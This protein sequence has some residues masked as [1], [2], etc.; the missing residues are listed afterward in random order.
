[1]E[2]SARN[3]D[4]DSAREARGGREFSRHADEL[5]SPELALVDP[6]PRLRAHGRRYPIAHAAPGERPGPHPP[7]PLPRSPA[8]A[9][10][11]TTP[12][13]RYPLWARITAAL[14]IL[15]LGILIGGAAIPHAQDRPRVVPPE[16]DVAICERPD[17]RPLPR[18]IGPAARPDRQ[19]VSRRRGA[20]S[21]AARY[22]RPPG[23][24]A[25]LGEHLDR[26]QGV[27]GSSPPSSTKACSFEPRGPAT[28]PR[29]LQ[30]MTNKEW[31]WDKTLFGG[32]ARYYREGRLA[33]PPDLA[34]AFQ[35]ELEL[36]GTGRLLDV[37]CGTGK[38]RS[39]SHRCT[40]RALASTPM[41]R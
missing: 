5:I 35:E 1:M 26:T 39:Y 14:W 40:K 12:S 34:T 18:P 6:E 20:G 28:G 9:P 30:P 10:T 31:E 3:R 22:N 21:R 33:Y 37:G 17:S 24:I 7:P 41:R 13:R 27:G 23:A 25:Q 32:S 36:D 8:G 38:S 16:E 19:P 2:S 4:Q 15:V 11:G 29:L